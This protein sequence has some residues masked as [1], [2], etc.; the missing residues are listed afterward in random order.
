MGSEDPLQNIL[1]G[2]FVQ[3]GSGGTRSDHGH[4]EIQT[5]PIMPRPNSHCNEEF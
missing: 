4:F 5:F 2:I 3:E 1:K